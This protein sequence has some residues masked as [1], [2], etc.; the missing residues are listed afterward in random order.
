MTASDSEST[1][2]NGD[3]KTVV[4]YTDG[5]CIGNPGP[6][7]WAAVLQYGDERKELSGR[8]RHTTNNR[9]ELRAAIEALDALTRPC[10][11]ILHT[12]STYVRSGIT[13][14]VKNWQRNGWRTSAKKP[15]KNKDLWQLLLAAIERHEPAG[16]VEWYW[17]KGHA[18]DE[19]NERA[20]ELANSAARSV[21]DTDPSD[22]VA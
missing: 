15:V 7:G 6:G 1:C 17:L 10:Q 18:G 11:V 19:L 20:D 14:W 13:E 5:G 4:V 2:L 12:D 22:R 8:F 3:A 9:M 21:A 16:G